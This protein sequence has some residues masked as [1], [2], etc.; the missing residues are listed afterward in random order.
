MNAETTLQYLADF[1]PLKFES[2]KLAVVYLFCVVNNGFVWRNG[3][4][5]EETGMFDRYGLKQPVAKA[6]F[7]H[8][9][10]YIDEFYSRSQK[11]VN[12]SYLEWKGIYINKDL[13]DTYLYKFPTD[14]TPDW[15]E[16]RQEC[17]A[18]G[19]IHERRRY[20]PVS[21]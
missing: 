15:E 9:N 4:L 8:D 1:R 17:L 5:V 21:L 19:D 20:T 12:K 18:Y 10:D 3:E 14:I 16:L 7:E 2:R 6:V 11:I 13:I